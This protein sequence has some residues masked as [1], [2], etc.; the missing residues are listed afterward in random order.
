MAGCEEAGQP[1]FRSIAWLR[2]RVQSIPKD[3]GGDNASLARMLRAY[4]FCILWAVGE[5]CTTT[6]SIGDRP[7]KVAIALIAG[8]MLLAAGSGAD[9]RNCPLAGSSAISCSHQIDVVRCFPVEKG[10][11]VDYGRTVMSPGV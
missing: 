7:A 2:T 10:P 1:P 6:R 3:G 8:Q 4:Q 11:G 5:I 9:R